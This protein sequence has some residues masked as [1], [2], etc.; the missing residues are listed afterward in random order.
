MKEYFDKKKNIRIRAADIHIGENVTLGSNI[1]VD[2]KGLFSIGDYSRLGNDVNIR[3]NSIILGQHLFHS[4]GLRIGGGGREN[5]TANFTCGDRCTI[6][7]NFINVCEPIKIGNDV[8]LS[9]E[10]SILSHGYWLSVLDG[11]PAAFAGVD[12][13]DGVIVG[14]RS[15]IMMGVAISPGCVIG[16]QSVV[17]KHLTEHGIYGGNPARFIREIR[18]LSTEA[19]IKKME[20]IVGAYSRHRASRNIKNFELALD[21]PFLK[22]DKL[23][24]NVESFVY[25]GEETQFSDDARDFLR[26]YGIR[27]YTERPFVS[28]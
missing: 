15:L 18:P 13:S 25:E 12:I 19:K 2:I 22:V 28:L 24:I 6:H 1:D 23:Q 4:S 17:T 16:A 26:K 8:G 21:F 14:Y 9:P 11:Y 27:V 10:T 20:E 7:N 5:M 3:G